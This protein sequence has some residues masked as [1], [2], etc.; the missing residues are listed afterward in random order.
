MVMPKNNP[1]VGVFSFFT[2]LGFLDLGFEKTPGYEVVFANDNTQEFADS[3][4]YSR[5]QMGLK[6]PRY[7]YGVESVEDY[8]HGN[9]KEMLKSDIYNARQNF[10]LVGFIAG[11]PC[12]DFSVGGKNRGST[13]DHGRLSSIYFDVIVQQKPDFFLFENVKGLWRT[14][15]HREFFEKLK[16]RAHKA[17]YIT[18]EKL[19]NAR[20]YGVPQDRDRI[21]LIG[22]KKELLSKSAHS[23]NQFN[24]EIF[25]WMRNAKY[26]LE[27]I[28]SMPWPTAN[29]FNEDGSLAK[30]KGII[31]ELTADYWFKKNNVE[32]HPNGKDY[33]TPRAGLSKFQKIDE[34]DDKKKSYKRLHRWRY[35][36]TC[37]YGNNEVHLHPYKAR[38][39]SVAEALSLQSLPKEFVLPPDATLSA[40]FKMIGNGV[41]YL[42]SKSIADSLIYFL[43]KEVTVYEPDRRRVSDSDQPAAKEPVLPIRKPK[44]AV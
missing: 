32:S 3:Y 9:K 43:D 27:D 41:P 8:T 34:G 13:G 38:R 40:K 31:E 6:T 10:D 7:G 14:K 28:K 39:I 21:L 11:P 29:E 26:S 4:Q 35:S 5:K 36:P 19:V 15:K 1:K 12:P 44:Y 24:P 16:V 25:P 42:L 33:F 22:V 2:G 23:N 37:A 17:G 30:P 18:T 20:E